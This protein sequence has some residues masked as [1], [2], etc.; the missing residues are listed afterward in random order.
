[1]SI[2]LGFWIEK[3]KISLIINNTNKNNFQKKVLK[4]ILL[5]DIFIFI[6]LL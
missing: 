1:M 6:N 5:L 4:Y 3:N 2:I